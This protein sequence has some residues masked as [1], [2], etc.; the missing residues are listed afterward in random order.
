MSTI[1]FSS[2][3]PRA[4]A[5]GAIAVVALSVAGC[6]GSPSAGPTSTG[7]EQE[8]FSVVFQPATESLAV[9]N[10]L[11]AFA[12]DAFADAGIDVTYNPV[13]SNAVQAS[14]A[15][16]TGSADIGIVGSNGVMSAV[17][18]G[19]DVVSVA[20]ITKG[21]TTQITLRDDVIE[22][23]DVK[24]TDPIE[25][26]IEALKGL[27]LALPAPGS[28][29]DLAVREMLALYDLVPD[30]DLTIR[31]LSEPAALVTATREGQV[32]GL[33]F[34]T[35]TSVQPVNEGYA[36]VWLSLSEV[37]EYE[38][39][40]FIDVI[41]SRKFLQE[42]RPAVL[43][44]VRV[45]Q[46]AA[47]AVEADPEAAGVVIRS[48]YFEDIDEALWDLAW[49][50]SYPRAIQGFFPSEEGFDVMLEVINNQSDQPVDVDYTDVYD[51]SLLDEL[52]SSR[53]SPTSTP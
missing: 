44:F 48:A 19:L 2:R 16:A 6:T 45:L 23:L 31:P 51:L 3:G 5:L 12:N 10:Q 9:V 42:N 35:P 39:L 11:Y 38:E 25:D 29:T 4:L 33:A 36:S 24:A 14:Q 43:A 32:D 40:P 50:S 27:S 20:T 28:L 17:G 49:E 26:R 37:P 41:T 18:S 7:G 15:V 47:D 30:Q 46:E 22:T 21:S 1:R 53:P 34:S 8:S 13:I 52:E